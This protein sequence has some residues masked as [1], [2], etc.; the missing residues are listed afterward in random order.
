[1]ASDPARV[2]SLLEALL[3][4]LDDLAPPAL[5]AQLAA[6]CAADGDAE[7]AR[8]QGLRAAARGV[9]GAVSPLCWLT[10]HHPDARVRDDARAW[11]ATLGREAAAQGRPA[12]ACGAP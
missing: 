11:L 12:P 6:H 7:C 4:A 1:M 9:A 2:R 10:A 8:F 5:R 3:T